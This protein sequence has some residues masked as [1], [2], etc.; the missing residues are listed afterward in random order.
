V[1]LIRSEPDEFSLVRLFLCHGSRRVRFDPSRLKAN[2]LVLSKVMSEQRTNDKIHRMIRLIRVD[3]AGNPVDLR[4]SPR[5]F[6]SGSC[7]VWIPID[8]NKLNSERITEA[9]SFEVT[10]Q[11]STT[12]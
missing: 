12:D 1:N 6:L 5:E 9:R 8:T 2:N 4:L 7:G 10:K 3:F 11:A